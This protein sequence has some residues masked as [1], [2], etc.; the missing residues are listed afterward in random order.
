MGFLSKALFLCLCAF[1]LQAQTTPEPDPCAGYVES[2]NSPHKGPRKFNVIS[3]A[4]S[5]A[6]SY[7]M[8]VDGE[9]RR[10]GHD[11]EGKRL[12][13]EI[14]QSLY[15]DEWIAE[16]DTSLPASAHPEEMSIYFAQPGRHLIVVTSRKPTKQ[17]LSLRTSTCGNRWKKEIT[18]PAS[19][20]GAVSRFTLVY[21]AKAKREP[22]LL[23][24]DHTADQPH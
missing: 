13:T 21:D 1:P 18:I 4:Y 12:Y 20:K 24:G 22:Q 16:A 9:G 14:P 6:D 10:F 7:V 17:V 5:A 3:V 19:P 11:S 8:I 2:P 15:E 23:D